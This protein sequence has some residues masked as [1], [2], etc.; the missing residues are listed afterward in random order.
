MAQ[1]QNSSGL[2]PEE[3]QEFATQLMQERCEPHGY[4]T[5]RDIDAAM[6]RIIDGTYGICLGTGKSINKR[7]LM[8]IPWAKYSIE[9][10]NFMEM[11][12]EFYDSLDPFWDDQEAPH[13]A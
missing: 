11:G 10:A 1:Q 6:E 12:L 4:G 13:A 3:I 8:A 7:R 5:I 9:Y 2:T